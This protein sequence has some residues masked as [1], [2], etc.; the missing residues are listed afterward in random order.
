M[1]FKRELSVKHYLVVIVKGE[2]Y[3]KQKWRK[4]I[5]EKAISFMPK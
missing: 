1:D 4:L 3:A 5:I 2:N